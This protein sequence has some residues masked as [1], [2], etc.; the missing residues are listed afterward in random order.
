M[1]KFNVSKSTLYYLKRNKNKIYNEAIS[2]ENIYK[3]IYRLNKMEMDWVSENIKP[4]K[5][6]LTIK[7]ILN[8]L[9][10]KLESRVKGKDITNFLKKTLKYSYKKGSSTSIRGASQKIHF[11]KEY[12]HEEWW[13]VFLQINI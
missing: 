3:D 4:L 8:M 6:P 2:K 1:L 12:F 10:S 9:N 11:N 7:N 5:A 13:C